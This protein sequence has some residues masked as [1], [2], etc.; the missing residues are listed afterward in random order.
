[1][2]CCQVVSSASSRALR[3]SWRAW[4]LSL[5]MPLVVVILDRAS[6]GAD[7][8]SSA[9]P[10]SPSSATT[11]ASKAAPPPQEI[12]DRFRR[13]ETLVSKQADQIRHLSEENRGLADQV[14]RLSAAASDPRVKPGQT[15]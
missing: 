7:S 5:C 15:D 12:E 9:A 1:M 4:I 10:A 13:L 14:R 11:P 8:P 3:G 6:A 2:R